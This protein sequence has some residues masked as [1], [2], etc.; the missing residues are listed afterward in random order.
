MFGEFHS[1]MEIDFAGQNTNPNTQATASGF[2][3]RLRRFYTDFG[4]PTG[5]WGAA[6]LGQENFVFSDNSLIPI[7]WLHDATFVG[8]S[9][10]R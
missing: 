5:G 10:V 9:N 3:P 8:V 6:L 2:T 7:Q 4:K 1:M